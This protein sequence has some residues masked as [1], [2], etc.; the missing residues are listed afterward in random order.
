MERAYAREPVTL[1]APRSWA[2][3]NFEHPGCQGAIENPLDFMM[4]Q[5]HM[6]RC[7]FEKGI[8]NSLTANLS[9]FLKGGA[10]DS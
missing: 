4:S 3:C 5:E 9:P 8:V 10:M 7:V 2:R 1:V 6:T